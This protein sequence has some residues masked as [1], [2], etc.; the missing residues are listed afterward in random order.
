MSF[1]RELGRPDGRPTEAT[2]RKALRELA[3]RKN[4][5]AELEIGAEEW[6]IK[7]P[8]DHLSDEELINLIVKAHL[9]RQQRYN[10]NY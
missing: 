8:Y 7:A 1:D 10:V 4:G 6:K 2:M 5:R 9:E 3:R